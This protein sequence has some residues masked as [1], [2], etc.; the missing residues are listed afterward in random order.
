MTVSSSRGTTTAKSLATSLN[1]PVKRSP[2]KRFCGCPTPRN[3]RQQKLIVTV[4]RRLPDDCANPTDF[5][6]STANVFY[7]PNNGMKTTD[8]VSA[9]DKNHARL[10]KD[11]SI[12]FPKTRYRPALSIISIQKDV[13]EIPLVFSS[14]Y[15]TYVRDIY[16]Y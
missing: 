4:E 15:N 13:T 3:C 11:F 12:T 9:R 8:V 14:R 16:I 2:D 5:K 7:C 10:S 6:V 1:R